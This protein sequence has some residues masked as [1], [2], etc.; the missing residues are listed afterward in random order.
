MTFFLV[1][2]LCAV[3]RN[4]VEAALPIDIEV[5]T[6]AG[7]PITAPQQWAQLLGTMD[8]G[9]VR[10]RPAGSDEEPKVVQDGSRYKIIALLDGRGRLVIEGRRYR[11][12]DR[13]ALT[14]FFKSLAEDE[15][16][17]QE[18]GRFN[19]T[20][21][22][23]RQVFTELSQPIEFSTQGKPLTSIL[24]QAESML[25][26]PLEQ[27][28]AIGRQLRQSKP[29]TV[30]LK[31]MSAGTALAIALREAEL[32]LVPKKPPGKP[33]QL[34]IERELPPREVWPTG[35]KP[36]G[37]PRKAAPKLFDF[38]TIEVEG[39]TLDKALAALEPRMGIKVIYDGRTLNRVG[40]Q[41]EKVQVSHPSGKTYLKRVIDRMLSQARLAGELRVDEDD[42]VFYWITQFGPRSRRAE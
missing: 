15:A 17:G 9:R 42:H 6:E 30:E 22:Q 13:K 29:V 34:G 16:Y 7:V 8:L 18:R 12:G 4:T 28:R 25:S 3:G 32:V 21:P 11:A 40:I 31:G 10:I 38:L 39:Y 26:L 35:W 41:P 24:R 5:A 33:L 2:A 27:D 19:L 36:E 20:E 37:S 1:A 14:E 23:F